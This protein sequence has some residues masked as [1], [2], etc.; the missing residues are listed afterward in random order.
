MKFYYPNVNTTA[1]E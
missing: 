1:Q